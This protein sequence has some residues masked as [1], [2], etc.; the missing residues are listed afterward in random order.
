MSPNKWA[1]YI[2]EDFYE[3]MSGDVEKYYMTAPI[4]PPQ[5]EQEWTDWYSDMEKNIP[6]N[7]IMIFGI[8]N[9]INNILSNNIRLKTCRIL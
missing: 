2:H 5:T 4:H 3:I 8:S 6:N 9:R 7:A 1:K